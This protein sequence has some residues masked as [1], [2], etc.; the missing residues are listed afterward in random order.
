M[1][2]NRGVTLV[3]LVVVIV[4]AAILAGV[5]I[6]GL[7]GV[8]Q[9]RAAAAAKRLQADC[10]HARNLAI[11]SSR[12]TAIVI[13]DAGGMVYQ[14]RQEATP[15]AGALLTTP[16]THPIT[17][18]DWQVAL[19]GL[20]S[21]LSLLSNNGPSDGVIGFD[22]DGMPIDANGAL[23]NADVTLSLSSGA[24]IKIEQQTGIA[25]MIWP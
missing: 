17:G 4:I 15:S 14:L 8:Q 25:E 13:V 22:A 12:R 11:L 21:G 9:W 24:T 23:W 10:L 1:K 20:A 16:L 7:S 3:E 6:R 2:S 5:S 19:G 18:Q